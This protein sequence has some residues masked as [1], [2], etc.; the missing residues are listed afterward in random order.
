MT[1]DE[2]RLNPSYGARHLVTATLD[3]G[4]IGGGNFSFLQYPSGVPQA[5]F[6]DLKD[7]FTQ[8]LHNFEVQISG[9]YYMLHFH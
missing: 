8:F 6:F 9:N 1:C 2:A 3:S 7:V 4:Q 5:K